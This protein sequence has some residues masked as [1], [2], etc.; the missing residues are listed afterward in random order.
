MHTCSNLSPSGMTHSAYFLLF[1]SRMSGYFFTKIKVNYCS[2]TS[3]KLQRVAILME[4]GI[5]LTSK[6]VRISG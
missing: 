5:C 6:R 4:G 3:E 1:S 2:D